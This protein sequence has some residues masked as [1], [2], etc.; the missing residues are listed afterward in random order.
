LGASN[1]AN[2]TYTAPIV[3]GRAGELSGIAPNTGSTAKRAQDFGKLGDPM[4]CIFL[5][6]AAFI[7]FS[8]SA[9]C[10]GGAGLLL[11]PI[12][13]YSLPLSQVPAALTL[14]TA[15]SSFSRIWI[16]FNAIRWDMAKLFLPTAILGVFLGAKM[17]SYLEP[18]YLEL[19][20]GLFL[21]SNLPWLFKKQKIKPTASPLH[22]IPT[23]QIRLVGFLAGFISGL[24]GAVGVLFNRFYFRYGL[25]NDEIIATRAANEV[26]L[27]VIKLG[28]YAS[29]GLFQLRT[30]GIGLIVA[31]AAVLSSGLMKF[32]L[33]RISRG[34]FMR[35]GYSAMVVSGVFMLNRAV[36]D[37]KLANDPD[38]RL[39]VQATELHARLTWN[40]LIYLAEVS[41]DEGLEFEKV[42]SL[43]S[44]SHDRQH[45]VQSLQDGAKRVDIEK[46][47]ARAGVS[48]EAYYFDGQ[49]RLINKVKFD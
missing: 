22:T 2:A 13:G 48:Y 20:M 12:L 26:L 15:T 1:E 42:V 41:Y 19:C 46:V 38:L 34:L 44:L 30:L 37:I 25:D 47:Y 31:L 7:A 5:F 14:G 33:P 11:I 9:I 16:F 8:L 27:H 36:V 45:Y 49:G 18:M 10:G 21:V 23:W 35:A 43:S 4:I 17:L 6:T 39:T 29:L 24:T 32:A 40:T 3:L 28:L